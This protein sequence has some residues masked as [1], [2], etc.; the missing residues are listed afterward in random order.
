MEVIRILK[1]SPN[2]RIGN[3]LIKLI[4]SWIRKEWC[5]VFRHVPRILNH[6]ADRMTSLG[7]LS[8]RDGLSMMSPPIEV[9]LLVEEEKE[10]SISDPGVSQNWCNATTVTFFKLQSDPGG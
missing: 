6:V 3:N 2:S 9:S 7:R 4:W 8:P 10:L 5:L 1:H